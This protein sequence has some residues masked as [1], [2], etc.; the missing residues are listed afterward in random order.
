MPRNSKGRKRP[1]SPDD[2]LKLHL[3]GD[4]QISPDGKRILFSKKHIGDK[5]DYVS[6][7]WV[8][9]TAGGEARQFT[10]SGKD[11]HARWSPDGSK[12]AFTSGRDK[13]KAQIF[14]MSSTGGEAH[15]LTEFPEGSVGEFKWSPD[16]KSLAVSFRPLEEEWAEAA[17]K[18]RESK[19]LSTPA[20]VIDDLWYRLD[21]D[22]YFNTARHHLYIVEAETG[23]HRKVFDKSPF[24][25]FSFDWSPDSK[26]LAIASNLDKQAW[27]RPWKDRLYLL[28]AKSGKLSLV[29]G[30]VDGTKTAVAWS[31]NG[32]MIAYAGRNGRQSLWGALNDQLF[33][34]DVATGNTRNLTEG[35][36]Y[37]LGSATLSDT[38]EAGF[39]CN[40]RWAP[41]SSRIFMGFGWHGEGHISAVPAKGGKIT[42]LTKG[43]AE[44]ML[45]NISDDGSKM[46][47]TVGDFLEPNEVYVGAIRKDA[48]VATRLTEFN[49]KFLAGLELAKPTM[50]WLTSPSGTR[51][52]VWSV[53]PPNLRPG[54]KAPAVLE[55]HGGPHAQY[56]VPFFHEFQVLA[57]AGYAVFFSNPRGSKGYGEDHCNSIHGA[58]GGVDWEDVQ[59]VAEYMKSRPFVDPKR[60]AV[61]GGSYGG[62]MTNWVIGHTNMFA[63]AIT[64]RC[65]SNLVSM[66]GNSDFPLVPDTY[67]SGNAWSKPET[68]WDQSPM[69]YMG[70]AKTPTLIIHSEGDLRCNVEQSEQVFTAL[71]LRGV[72]TRF[73]RYPQSTSHG[74]SRSGPPDL[75]IHRLNQI[76]D[77]Y[78]M[79]LAKGK[80][81]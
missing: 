54:A 52:Q 68:L 74:M 78:K 25:L 17:K 5:N 75:R 80:G 72:P 26:K 2:L 59:T 4:P 28:D 62:Y 43:P 56:G 71:K 3:I 33:V 60:M 22:G 6:N 38:R 55:I 19:G 34:C 76:L 16:G 64:D 45:G 44:Y 20:R 10:S 81:K 58:W 23:K 47:M 12:I 69:K 24:G 39:G 37:C 61:M 50:T 51:V 77:W 67:W 14:V 11:G 13:P 42:F 65:V 73:V 30:Q 27:S 18:E 70:N 79:Y 31:P 36:D 46:A 66:S 48:I 40:I 9:D 41:D 49:K 8:V 1:V 21:G 15:A 29:P 63:A 35:E 57:S 32:R 53:K 7:V